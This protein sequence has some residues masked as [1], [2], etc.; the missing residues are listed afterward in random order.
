MEKAFL[1]L[2]EFA[3]E[4]PNGSIVG[5]GHLQPIKKGWVVR[6]KDQTDFEGEA[7]MLTAIKIASQTTG[8][9][10]GS[11]DEE[12]ELWDVVEVFEN[13]DEATEAGKL[14]EQM[15]IFQIETGRLKWLS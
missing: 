1:Q 4:F 7:G 13:E 6:V 3:I 8:K 5:F 11:F 10:A 12:I 9:I 15:A 2:R 14:N